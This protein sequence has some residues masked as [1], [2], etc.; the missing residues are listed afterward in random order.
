MG[1][2]REETKG[3]NLSPP[4]F[5]LYFNRTEPFETLEGD[6]GNFSER[7]FYHRTTTIGKTNKILGYIEGPPGE[8]MLAV[9]VLDDSFGCGEV[10]FFSEVG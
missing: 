9:V 7:E 5:G 2:P 4:P 6:G 10:K 8:S 3:M 1:G